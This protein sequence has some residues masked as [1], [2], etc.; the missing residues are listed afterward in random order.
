MEW[1][2]IGVVAGSLVTAGFKDEEACL[3]RV[4][5]LKA[6]KIEA[7]CVAAPHSPYGITGSTTLQLQPPP[8]T[9]LAADGSLRAC[10]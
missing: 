6:Q 1:I 9:C 8:G 5:T 7:K 3:G 2:L 4:A 10:Q